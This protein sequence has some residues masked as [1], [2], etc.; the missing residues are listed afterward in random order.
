MTFLVDANVLSEPTKQTPHTKVL[1]W[2][3]K[4]EASLFVDSI[5]LGELRIGILALPRGRKRARLEEWFE[6]VIDTI[7]CLPW[8]AAVSRRWATLVVDL[9][10]KGISIPLL[11]GMI[12]ATALE[13]DLTI[14]TRNTRDFSKT[15]AKTFNPFE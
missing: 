6:A 9:K 15:G 8:D 5:I 7:E 14:A 12:A 10:R 2:L 1:E 11:D 3:T 4:N 13:Y